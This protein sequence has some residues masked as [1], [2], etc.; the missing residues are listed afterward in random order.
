MLLSLREPTLR[1]LAV[2]SCVLGVG[3]TGNLV[4]TADGGPGASALGGASAAGGIGSGPGSG[5]VLV[6]P[7]G[8]QVPEG[9]GLMP[10]R[11]LGQREHAR[12][13]SA[14]FGA[15]VVSN[16]AFPDDARGASSYATPTVVGTVERDRVEQ[17]ADA[18]A[19]Q[20]APRL[21][22]LAPCAAGA[23]ERACA[24]TFVT[25]FGKKVFRRPLFAAETDALLALYDKLRAPPISDSHVEALQTLLSALLQSPQFLYHWELGPSAPLIEGQFLR[26]NGYEIASRLSYFL[27][28]SMPDDALFAAA[29]AGTLDTAVGVQKQV[30]RLLLAPA[31]AYAFT[32]MVGQWINIEKL[33]GLGVQLHCSGGRDRSGRVGPSD[34]CRT[35]WVHSRG[36]MCAPRGKS[37]GSW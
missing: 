16:V 29:A 15:G 17:A 10:L 7:A 9:A 35:M 18:I 6:S 23:T 31:A 1:W 32:D 8:T 20:V 36:S 26:L 2:S 27:W 3:C 30:E 13:V 28:A 37:C 25:D 22:S 14:L 11:R 19:T 24:Q 21:T 4:G 5:G 33:P 12:T 34:P